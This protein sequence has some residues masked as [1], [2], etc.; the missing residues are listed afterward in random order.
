MKGALAARPSLVSDLDMRVELAAPLGP[1][2]W[3]RVGGCA[4]ALVSPRTEEALATLVRRCHDSGIACRVLGSG[5]NLLVDDDGIDGVVIRLD[6]PCFRRA[7]FANATGDGVVR[8]GAGTDLMALVQQSAREGFDGLAQLA[9]IPATLGGAITMN[10]GGAYG[11]TA[12]AVHEIG[13]LGMDGVVRTITAKHAGFAYRH[14]AIPAGVVL[15]ADLALTRG[16]PAAI[17]ERVKTI[18]SY[19]KSTQPMADRSAGCMFKNPVDPATGSRRSAGHLIDQ[20]GLKGTAV[21]GAY[22]SQIH[23]N[24][25]ALTEGGCT[26][27][28]LALAARVQLRVLEFSGIHLEREVVV[29]SKRGEVP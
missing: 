14:T 22:V 8:V 13:H 3:F 7:D 11:D 18:F 25:I 16:D 23:G 17:R 19:K 12:Q 24:F 5:A 4:D 28:V 6:E 21:G 26:S 2:T 20:A 9:G 1:L 15:F 27:D 10:A 29:W